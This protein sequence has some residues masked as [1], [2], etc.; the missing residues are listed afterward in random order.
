MLRNIVP[1]FLPIDFLKICS[2][3][4]IIDGCVGKRRNSDTLELGQLTWWFRLC[5]WHV[6]L[7]GLQNVWKDQS[8]VTNQKVFKTGLQD[9]Y[10]GYNGVLRCCPLDFPKV[11]AGKPPAYTN[12]TPPSLSQ[13]PCVRR[14]FLDIWGKAS[15]LIA[16]PSAMLPNPNLKYSFR[17]ALS[18]YLHLA[19][20]CS[21]MF[22]SP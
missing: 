16:I 1:N 3:L 14:L 5:W 8:G 9:N 18:F 7:R 22:P 15:L 4:Q 13:H 21:T 19:Y 17:A 2:I 6:D 20:F 12:L 11:Q 10:W